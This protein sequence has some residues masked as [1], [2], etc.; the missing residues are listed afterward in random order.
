MTKGPKFPPLH[1]AIGA[2]DYPA[3]SYLLHNPE[4]LLRKNWLGFTPLETAHLLGKIKMVKELD[5]RICPPIIL[6][7]KGDLHRRLYSRE[8]FEKIFNITYLQTPNFQTIELLEEVIKNGPWLLLN[9]VVGLEHRM[10]G[11]KYR[12]ALFDGFIADVSIRWI[13]DTM[14][15]GLFAENVIAKESYIG[16]YTGIVKKGRR[17]NEYSLRMPSRFWSFRAYLLDAMIAGNEMRFA[18]HSKQPNMKPMCLIDRSLVHIG[19]FATRQIEAG[20]ELTFNY[21]V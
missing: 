17:L 13:N 10:L 19:F 5:P 6:Q 1:L 11:S 14:G 7:K 16:Q 4:E 18:N 21:G 8:D 15:Y 3:F 12:H 20:E 2:G 9:T